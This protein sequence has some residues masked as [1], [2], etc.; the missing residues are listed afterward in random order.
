MSASSP[1]YSKESIPVRG[2]CK[3][4]IDYQGQTAKIPLLIVAG[5][6]PTLLG[7]DWLS[8]LRQEVHH[9]HSAS[10]QAVLAQFSTVFQEGLGTL[11]GYKVKI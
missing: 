6:G 11:K 9:V 5:S 10:L 3:V 4:N 8:Q 2:C 1:I 7:R